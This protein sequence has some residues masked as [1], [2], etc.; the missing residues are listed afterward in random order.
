MKKIFFII[1]LLFINKLFAIT[2]TDDVNRTLKLNEPINRV[3]SLSPAHTEMLYYLGLQN[4]LIG[5][6]ENCDFPP[7]AKNKIKAGTF[8]NPDIET[9]VNLKP[10]LVISGGG[11]QKKAIKKMEELG[12]NVIVLYP[13]SVD[14]IIANMDL[15]CEILNGD[16]KKIEIFKEKL[17]KTH[18]NKKIKTYLELWDKPRMAI[19]GNS[20][21]NDIVEY[22]GGENI[23]KN[24]ISE[25]PKISEEEILKKDPEVILLFYNP[26]KEK[27]ILF[28]NKINKK[29]KVFIIS[30][31]NQDV[32]LRPGPRVLDAIKVLNDIYDGIENEK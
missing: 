16:K 24:T 5:V 10:D 15:L 30:K 32:F 19:G 6:S 4:K 26:E 2:I 28:N 17:K 1:L 25:Y 12:H 11:I 3:I 29:Q 8:L 31:E 13:L 27:N 22:A 9:I 7:E 18:R 20:F 23:F 21:I 14:N